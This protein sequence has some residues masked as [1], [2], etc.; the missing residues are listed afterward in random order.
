MNCLEV[1]D[2]FLSGM[3]LNERFYGL[4]L[5]YKVS[6][7]DKIPLFGFWPKMLSADLIAGFFDQQYILS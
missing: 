4:L 5:F 2:P 7:V 6:W 1:S 3:I